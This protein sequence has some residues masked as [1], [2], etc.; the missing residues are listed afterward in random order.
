MKPT[1]TLPP[2]RTRM[3]QAVRVIAG[4]A[5]YSGT[6]DRYPCQRGRQAYCR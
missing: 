2:P 3:D 6:F 1:T 5:D 4:D